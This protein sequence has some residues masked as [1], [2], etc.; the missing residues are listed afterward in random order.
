MSAVVI[1]ILFNTA[2]YDGLSRAQQHSLVVYISAHVTYEPDKKSALDW[3]EIFM[4]QSV[5]KYK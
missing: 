4:K 5:G 2:C 3:R 1:Y